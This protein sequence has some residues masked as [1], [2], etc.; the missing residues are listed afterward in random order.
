MGIERM[1]MLA[2]ALGHPEKGFPVIHVAGTNGKGSVC[3]ML[4][5]FTGE[6]RYRTGLFSSRTCCTKGKGSRSTA[7]RSRR[8]HFA[9]D[10]CTG[11]VAGELANADPENHPS[12]LSG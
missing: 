2:E 6:G 9:L 1:A 5:G 8:G 10:E 11:A 4:R 3:A 12:F 7:C